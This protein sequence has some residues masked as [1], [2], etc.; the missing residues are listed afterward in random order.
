MRERTRGERG[1]GC[2]PRAHLPLLTP[3]SHFRHPVPP[4]THTYSN[5]KRAAIKAAHPSWGIGEIGKE[6]GQL[7]KSVSDADKAKYAKQAEKDKDRYKRELA[8]YKP[9]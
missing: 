7:W 2:C 9:A 1:G 5:D 8:A 4:T 6:L 3:H